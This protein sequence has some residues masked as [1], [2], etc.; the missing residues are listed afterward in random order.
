MSLEWFFRMENTVRMSLPEVC[1]GFEDY[2]IVFDTDTTEKHPSYIF[3][4][5]MEDGFDAFCVIHFDPVNQEFYSYYYDE[6]ADMTAKVLFGNGGEM[7]SF[8]HASFHEYVEE[9]EMDYV[10]EFD[11]FSLG[12]LDDDMDDDDYDD[13][14]H[15]DLNDEFDYEI[16][17]DTDE[18]DDDDFDIFDEDE[19]ADITWI[20][21]DKYITIED[22]GPDHSIKHTIHYRLGIDEETGDG[23]LYR[24]TI[25]TD[26]DDETHEKVKLYFLQE[27][28]SYIIDLLEEYI[29]QTNPHHH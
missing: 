21:N 4:I 24:S 5:E 12:S 11:N 29:S 1:E 3:S 13:D 20:T 8:I 7:L 28:A 6:E 17:Y 25:S 14:E 2:E 10:E 15:Y 16:E 9:V 26:D 18:Y 19:E 23:V 27:E 22:N